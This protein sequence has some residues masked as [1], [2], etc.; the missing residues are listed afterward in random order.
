MQISAPDAVH[1]LP[2]IGSIYYNGSSFVD[3]PSNRVQLL[4]YIILTPLQCAQ[5]LYRPL[6]A[7]STY[8][9]S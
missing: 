1:I 9:Q 6:A 5:T 8:T 4:E 3:M 7:Q 2:L